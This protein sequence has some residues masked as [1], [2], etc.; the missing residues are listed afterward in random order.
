MSL[1]NDASSIAATL[2]RL[3]FGMELAP[4]AKAPAERLAL[5]DFEAC[6]F[7][8]KVRE[9]L[10]HLGLEVEMRPVGKGSPRRAELQQRG[11]K[12]MAPYLVDPNSGSEMYESDDIVRYLYTTYADGQVPLLQSLGPLN[13]A[14]SAVASAIRLERGVRARVK[15]PSPPPKLLELYNMESSPYCRKVRE[16]LVELDLP[17]VCKNAPRR[18][19][20]REELR[21]LG[22][23]VM[24]PYL[25][26]PNTGRAMYESDDIVRYLD[27]T[28]GR[29][30]QGQ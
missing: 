21:R 12:I 29:S 20:V 28:Y 2:V 23:K 10:S 4:G 9:A 8:R 25:A 6:P 16:A 24:V 1:A 14:L 3:G 11:G 19:A 7:C 13:T 30:A 26:D 18:S 22:G 27:E 5:Y 17:Y 15:R